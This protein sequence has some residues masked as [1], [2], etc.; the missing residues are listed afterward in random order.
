MNI[1]QIAQECCIRS[2]EPTI[3]NLFADNEAEQEWLGYLQQA[4]KKIHMA[5]NW[6]D[7]K[8]DYHFVT[9]SHEKTD[10]ELPTDYFAFLTY[11]IYNSTKQEKIGNE[12]D[13]EALSVA[14]TNNTSQSL[15][16]FR[17]I[18]GMIRFTYA[19]EADQALA[20]NYKIKDFAKYVD[21]SSTTYC[22]CFEHNEDTFLLDD[23]LLI[24]CVL[25]LRSLALGFADVDRRALD[26]SRRMD[27]LIQKDDG[28]RI[29]NTLM[30]DG[31]PNKTTNADWNRT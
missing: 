31:Y 10:Y 2:K 16:K 27:Q 23:E 13:E 1:L 5:H 20:F 12:S 29:A 3:T 17:L 4:A 11:F 21:D 30:V 8:E 15:I 25:E 26:C 24:L 7:L 14:S 28:V 22:D 6:A 19:I 9:T 18:R